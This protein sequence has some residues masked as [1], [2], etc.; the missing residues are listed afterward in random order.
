[1]FILVSFD[2]SDL[3]YQWKKKLGSK[4]FIY[5]AEMAQFTVVS[6]T[7]ALKHPLYHSSKYNKI[8]NTYNVL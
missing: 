6:V 2:E 3:K 4:V 1:M 7:R 5:D 8:K